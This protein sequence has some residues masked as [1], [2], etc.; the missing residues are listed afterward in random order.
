MQNKIYTRFTT[1][2]LK[3]GKEL[4]TLIYEF[5]KIEDKLRE[6]PNVLYFTLGKRKK[7]KYLITEYYPSE[8]DYENTPQKIDQLLDIFADKQSISTE[9]SIPPPKFLVKLTDDNNHRLQLKDFIKAHFNEFFT[10]FEAYYYFFDMEECKKIQ[11]AIYFCPYAQLVFLEFNDDQFKQLGENLLQKLVLISKVMSS[12]YDEEVP[13]S[14]EIEEELVEDRG[15]SKIREYVPEIQDDNNDDSTVQKKKKKDFLG[16]FFTESNIKWINNLFTNWKKSNQFFVPPG[17]HVHMKA[18]QDRPSPSLSVCISKHPNDIKDAVKTIETHSLIGKKEKC[19]CGFWKT[20]QNNKYEKKHNCAFGLPIVFKIIGSKISVEYRITTSKPPPSKLFKFHYSVNGRPLK[21]NVV[22]ENKKIKLHEECTSDY[23]VLEIDIN[24]FQPKKDQKL[25][26]YCQYDNG[27]V[28]L[29]R[30]KSFDLSNVSFSTSKSATPQIKDQ[31]IIGSLKKKLSNCSLNFIIYLYSCFVGIPMQ[32]IISK[33]GI[34]NDE[35]SN[36]DE[37][38]KN[39]LFWY[40]I[41]NDN[42]HLKELKDQFKEKEFDLEEQFKY[43]DAYNCI[44]K[45]VMKLEIRI[46]LKNYRYGFDYSIFDLISK[47]IQDIKIGQ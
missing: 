34:T 16:S 33:F 30:E 7:G 10:D 47:K 27:I 1:F 6:F 36:K 43:V 4:N 40:L 11:K 29:F 5:K 28:V 26:L 46:M 13:T 24:E 17:C 14:Q 21:E 31:G 37:E 8:V 18:T 42:I 38:G 25:Q 20:M 2:D 41:F 32:K 44:D 3:E 39:G 22:F 35:I 19:T 15:T 9:V 23:Y 45:K 12:I